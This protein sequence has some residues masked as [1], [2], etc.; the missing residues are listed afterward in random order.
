MPLGEQEIRD[1]VDTIWTSMLKV[2]P[3]AV[4]VELPP[5]CLFTFRFGAR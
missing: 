4:P 5:T 1:I 2:G 3:R